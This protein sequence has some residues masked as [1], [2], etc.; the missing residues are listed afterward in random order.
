MKLTWQKVGTT[1]TIRGKSE[2]QRQDTHLTNKTI[3][4][5]KL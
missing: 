3:P 2:L 5:C 4:Y 1:E